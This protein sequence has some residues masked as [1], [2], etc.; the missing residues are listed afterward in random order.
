MEDIG[1]S[2]SLVIL[3]TLSAGLLFWIPSVLY[4]WVRGNKFG[5]IDVAF[6]TLLLPILSCWCLLAIWKHW[7]KP[8]NRIS[9]C[10]LGIVGIWLLGPLMMAISASFS[11]GG[12]ARSG[13]RQFVAMGTALFPIFTYM[14]SAYDGTLAAILLVTLCLGVLALASNRHVASAAPPPGV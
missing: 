2:V 12:F 5:G 11:G 4:H 8:A 9:R 13:G 14:M 1:N 10:L 3:D 6:L 7:R